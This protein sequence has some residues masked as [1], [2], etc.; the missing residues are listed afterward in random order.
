MPTRLPVSISASIID[1]VKNGFDLTGGNIGT[2]NLFGGVVPNTN[3]GILVRD[4]AHA[5]PFAPVGLGNINSENYYSG[6]K[7]VKIESPNYNTNGY[8]PLG[9]NVSEMSSAEDVAINGGRTSLIHGQI[10]EQALNANPSGLIKIYV[11]YFLTDLETNEEFLEE[12]PMILYHYGQCLT[13]GFYGEI[14]GRGSYLDLMGNQISQKLEIRMKHMRTPNNASSNSVS[15]AFQTYIEQEGPLGAPTNATM[16]DTGTDLFHNSLGDTSSPATFPALANSLNGQILPF[17]N[18]FSNNSTAG[19]ICTAPTASVEVVNA[20]APDLEPNNNAD[21]TYFNEIAAGKQFGVCFWG[22]N[23]KTGFNT[24]ALGPDYHQS[25]LPG[26]VD[27]GVENLS[28]SVEAGQFMGYTYFRIGAID[29]E[30]IE[31][32]IP[33]C[34]DPL[35]CNYDPGATVNDGSCSFAEN[36]YLLVNTTTTNTSE[37][38]YDT[39]VPGQT[40]VSGFSAGA[41]WG[42]FTAQPGTY[43]ADFTAAGNPTIEL[44]ISINNGVYFV[45]FSEVMTPSQSTASGDLFNVNTGANAEITLQAGDTMSWYWAVTPVNSTC[46]SPKTSSTLN[47][48]APDNQVAGCTS[49]TAYNY[50]SAATLDDG[51]CLY[52]TTSADVVEGFFPLESVPSTDQNTAN[53]STSFNIIPGSS[54]G[55]GSL[56]T[57]HVIQHANPNAT[58]SSADVTSYLQTGVAPASMINIQTIPFNGVGGGQSVSQFTIENLEGGKVFT[59][60][61]E[62]DGGYGLNSTC[63]FQSNFATQYFDCTDPISVNQIIYTNF[64]SPVYIGNAG[65]FQANVSNETLC[66]FTTDCNIINTTVDI[67]FG[68]STGSTPNNCENVVTIFWTG[69]IG[70]LNTI[71]TLSNPEGVVDTIF[72]PSG[73]SAGTISSEEGFITRDIT[74][75]SGAPVLGS[76][77]ANLYVTSA[78][79][80]LSCVESDT[81]TVQQADVSIC[82]CTNSNA[83]NYD[84]LAT[85]DDGSCTF[86]GCTDPEAFNFMG[87]ENASTALDCSGNYIPDIFGAGN[88]LA[89]NSC[90]IYNL[91]GCTDSTATNYNFQATDDDGTC[92][93]PVILGC[94]D[95]QQGVLNYNPLAN[96]DDGTCEY[97]GCTD[98]T[99]SNPTYYTVVTKTGAIQVLANIDNGTC[100]YNQGQVPG[101]TDIAADNYNPDA[102]VNVGCIYDGVEGGD[103]PT[104]TITLVVPNYNDLI[105]ILDICVSKAIHSYYVKL[106]TGQKCDKTRVLHLTIV[107]HLLDNRGIKCLFDGSA[108]S[109]NKLNKL[110]TFALSACDD[111]ELDIA[112]ITSTGLAG[113]IETI[114]PTNVDFLQS[115]DG[116]Y[117]QEAN[118][119]LFIETN[120]NFNII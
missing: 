42:S 61:V 54:F 13:T 95:N 79:G 11:R 66:E 73:G 12:Q 62:V 27:N 63:F 16:Y 60:L 78:D 14:W 21:T 47:V 85:Q 106:I 53:A 82:G 72:S 39:T 109:I 97:T 57:L 120:T 17:G 110:I 111:C 68:T 26:T 58:I 28:N 84:P 20:I 81:L 83:F 93:Y 52:C 49:S 25:P 36:N 90:C 46:Y 8:I 87:F 19:S 15:G 4:M 48:T 99:A 71:L 74:G 22:G 101:C 102:T 115:A 55:T 70:G 18:T 112:D 35:A 31:T 91:Y 69:A 3:F 92:I 59:V 100:F 32:Y 89:D 75:S 117:V 119:N 50:N 5:S 23:P 65:Q 86:N 98:V 6:V 88:S 77:V 94:T 45:A 114:V 67:E 9:A 43:N 30:T 64:N 7:E 76:Y 80:S 1:P 2:P 40:T 105:D 103:G 44:F 24:E 118:G 104:P 34:T 10:F 107:K 113:S 38:I 33:G 108:N 56:G 96:L 116:G 37:A 41:A 51:S 29:T